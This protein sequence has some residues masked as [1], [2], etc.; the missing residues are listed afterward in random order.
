MTRHNEQQAMRDWVV[1]K[2]YNVFCTLKFKNGYDIDPQRAERLV[3]VFL[4]R[5]DRVYWGKRVEREN[6]RCQRFVFLHKGTS[7][8]N[9]HFHMLLDAVGHTYTFL[10]VVRGIWSGFAETDLANSRF[11]VARNTAATGTYCLHEW[12]KLGGMTF[13]ARLSH[14]IPPTSMEKGKNLQRVRRLLKAIDS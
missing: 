4:Q 1:E 9:T 10:Q 2:G 12:S 7:G 3:Q 8:Q 5:L 11:E 6:L 13:C 14:T